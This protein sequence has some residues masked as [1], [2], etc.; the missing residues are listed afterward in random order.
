MRLLS[1]LVLSMPEGSQN[2]YYYV[3]ARRIRNFTNSPSQYA[4]TR[5][6]SSIFQQ[7]N[8]ATGTLSIS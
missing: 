8:I 1:K 2:T 5:A 4:D 6:T 7:G 3:N